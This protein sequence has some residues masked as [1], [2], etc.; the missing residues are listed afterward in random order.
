LP[1]DHTP[2]A[3]LNWKNVPYAEKL[4]KNDGI[5]SMVFA[6]IDEEE[7]EGQICANNNCCMGGGAVHGA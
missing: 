3:A 1:S 4:I 5:D 6:T 2:L 7:D